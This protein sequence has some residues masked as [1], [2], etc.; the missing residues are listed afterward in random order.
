MPGELNGACTST[1]SGNR[2]DG[3]REKEGGKSGIRSPN[4]S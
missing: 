2:G 4:R 1:K 3:A